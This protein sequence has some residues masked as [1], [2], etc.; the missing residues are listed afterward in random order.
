MDKKTYDLEQSK[1][2]LEIQLCVDDEYVIAK[3]YK[4]QL[5]NETEGKKQVEECVMK[6]TQNF[7]YNTPVDQW[8]NKWLKGLKITLCYDLKQNV[9]KMMYHQYVMPDKLS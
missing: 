5:I 3:M 2:E 8:E 7:D 4:L 9:Y 6:W 1:S